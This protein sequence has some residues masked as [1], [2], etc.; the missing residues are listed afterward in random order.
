MMV[1][2]LKYF[3]NNFFTFL[4]RTHNQNRCGQLG[5]VLN[6]NRKKVLSLSCPNGNPGGGV[7]FTVRVEVSSDK[8]VNIYLNDDL[9]T[10]LTSNF[11]ITG[12][13]GVFVR[14]GFQNIIRFRKFNLTGTN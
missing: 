10:S 11:S 3:K 4:F 1:Q 6:G 5:Y 12:R 13:G 7:W 14:N 2:I 9:T 8:S